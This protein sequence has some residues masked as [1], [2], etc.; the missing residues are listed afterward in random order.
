M[1]EVIIDALEL[2]ED[3]DFGQEETTEKSN[4]NIVTSSA[5]MY[6]REIGKYDLLSREKEIELAEAAA[7]GN[8][9]AKEILINHNL[10]LVVSIAKRYMGRGLTLLDLIQEGNIGLIKAVDKYD[11]SK[12][13]KFS[14]YATYWIKQSISRAIMDQSRNIRIP[15]HVIELM[16]NIKKIERELQQKLGRDPK[17]NEV[18]AALNIDTKKVKE[19]Y[20]WMK[21]TTS[22]DI[23]IGDDEDTTIGSLIEDESAFSDFETVEGSDRT[24]AIKQ[25]LDT[26]DEREKIVIVKRFGINASKAETLDEIGK[27]LKLSKERIRQIEAAALRKLRNP[28]R[29]KILKDFC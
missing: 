7:K 26:L 28:R 4:I 15:V 27:E 11:V 6:L 1:T 24:E 20:N 17:E 2:D 19:I 14:T 18:A 12:G 21:D 16:S 23:M 29:A 3:I 10:R 25:I 22:L 9:Q 8:K 5:K 13:F